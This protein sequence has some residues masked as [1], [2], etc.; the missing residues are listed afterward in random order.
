MMKRLLNSWV[1]VPGSEKPFLYRVFAFSR[2][3]GH[4]YATDKLLVCLRYRQAVIY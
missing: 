3:R 4:F 1:P 2:P